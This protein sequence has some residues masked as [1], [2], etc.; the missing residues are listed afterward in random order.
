LNRELA[1]DTQPIKLNPFLS[2][3]AVVNSWTKNLEQAL[4]GQMTFDELVAAV[5]N[6]VNAAISD[7]VMRIG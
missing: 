5:E 4:K 7:G 3:G 1:L 6:E 2:E